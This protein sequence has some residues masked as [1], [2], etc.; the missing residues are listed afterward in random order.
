MRRPVYRRTEVKNTYET[1]MDAAL[2]AEPPLI[3]WRPN[4]KG[5]LVAVK[6]RDPHTTRPRKVAA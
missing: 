4:G 1:E 6:I 2:S 5:V 3:V